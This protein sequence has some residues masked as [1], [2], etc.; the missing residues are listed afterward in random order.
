MEV[1]RGEALIMEQAGRTNTH[2]EREGNKNKAREI[3]ETKHLTATPFGV[4]AGDTNS[5]HGQASRNQGKTLNPGKS[6]LGLS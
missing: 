2:L 1:S 5:R 3:M 4:L 6:G